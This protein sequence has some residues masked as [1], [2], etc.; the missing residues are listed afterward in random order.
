MHNKWQRT[1]QEMEQ[2]SLTPTLL[3]LWT[4]KLNRIMPQMFSKDQEICQM[5]LIKPQ[6]TWRK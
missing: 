2:V 1:M 4:K 6:L 5:Y 3:S